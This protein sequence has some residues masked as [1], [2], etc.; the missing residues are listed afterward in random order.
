MKA[1]CLLSVQ[2]KSEAKQEST[3]AAWPR[4]PL[5]ITGRGEAVEEYNGNQLAYINFFIP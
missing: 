4:N 1:L 3:C 5:G 2:P